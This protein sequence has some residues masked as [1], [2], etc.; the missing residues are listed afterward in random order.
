MESYR[1]PA[2]VSDP[3]RGLALARQIAHM[4]YRAEAGLE[5]RHGR[6]QAKGGE[7]LVSPY[8][9]QTYLEHQG[10]ALCNRFTVGAYLAQ[11]DCMDNHDLARPPRQPDP[12]ERW[13]WTPEQTQTN[14]GLHRLECDVH[15]LSIL[16]DQLYFTGQSDAFVTWLQHN[17]RQATHDVL[18]NPHGHDGFLIDTESVGTWLTKQLGTLYG[19]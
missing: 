9:V 17:G 16:E 6:R 18:S 13:V 5:I 4:T 19:G 15:A 3:S 7:S 2:D 12:N 14:W 10:R 1:A 11:L 8:A